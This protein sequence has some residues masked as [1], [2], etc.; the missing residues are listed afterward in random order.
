MAPAMVKTKTPGVYKRGGRYVVT[1]RDSAGKS[2]KRFVATYD[3]AR[4]A[5]RAL[6]TDVARGE[7][8]ELS[9]ARFDEY[10]GEWIDT[11]QGRTTRGFRER[12]RATYRELL[13]RDAIP[14]FGRARLAAIEPRD[15]KR[16][17]AELDARGLKPASIRKVI[18]PV[19]ALFATAVEE[20]LVRSNPTA[21]VRIA[22]DTTIEA[23]AEEPTAKAL[24][25]DELRALLEHVPEKWRLLVEF[26]VHTGLRISETA[27]LEW[28]HVDLANRRVLVRRRYETGE[29]APPKS[30][31]GRRDV[32]L[33]AG[34]AAALWRIRTERRA[35]DG[36]PV[37]TTER[38]LLLDQR[39][40]RTKMLQPAAVAAGLG[41]FVPNGRGGVRATTWVA[42]RS[43]RHTCASTLFR[44]GLNAKQVQLWLGHHSPAFTLATYVHLMPEDLPDA[45][46]LDEVTA[47]WAT[48]GQH[49]GRRQ[50]ENESPLPTAIPLNPGETVDPVR[51]EEIAASHS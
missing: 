49:D 7:F 33:T 50:E 23:D 17:I 51:P 34:M 48:D 8:R 35:G 26:Q 42:W 19:R 32:P 18:A 6:E 14:F 16:F 40:L 21:G 43:L 4:N 36:D 41:A 3:E 2:R 29:F 24:T 39:R 37:F 15:V 5:K 9:R 30:R 20:G 47:R 28:R 44:R 11:Y 31:Y 25:E 45:A 13:E 12:T 38:G 22:V 1:F 27:G 10:A 46:F